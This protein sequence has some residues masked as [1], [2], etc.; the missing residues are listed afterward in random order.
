V[1]ILMLAPRVPYPPDHGAALRNLYLL[2]WLGVRHEVTLAGFGNPNDEEASRALRQSAHRVEIVPPPRRGPTDRLRVLFGSIGADLAYRLW[3]PA[4]IGRLRALLAEET[5]D[6]VQIEGL[7]MVALWNAARGDSRAA[8]IFDEHNAEYV[9]QASAYLASRAAG[10]WPG[11]V[12]S[13]IQAGRLRRFERQTLRSARRVIAVSEQD[14]AALRRL[15]PDVQ[16]ALI[17]NGVDTGYYTPLERVA[18]HQVVLFIGKLDYR[19]NLDAMDWLTSQIWPRV[20]AAAPSARLLIVGR[21]APARILR[22]GG[23]DGIEVIG[24]VADEREWFAR[25]DVLAVPMRMGS[26]VRLKVVQAMA[27]GTPVISTTLGMSGVGARDGVHASLADTAEEFAARTVEALEN[28]KLRAD[29]ARNGRELVVREFDWHV[30][31]PELDRI[32]QSITSPTTT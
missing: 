10:D 20:R 26:G 12:Y 15:A 24:P 5:Y 2:R 3:S 4:M 17:P 13:W 22:V 28:P 21:D 6:A 25:A 30:L 19:P 32:Y 18:S 16:P 8:V 1:R 31:L 27:T 7:E 14:R 23:R 11:A 29:L 9:L